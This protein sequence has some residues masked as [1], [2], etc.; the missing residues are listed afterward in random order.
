MKLVYCIGCGDLLQLDVTETKYCTC[1]NAGGKYHEGGLHAEYWGEWAV[2]V[3]IDSRD[4]HLAIDNQPEKG[5]G[6][7]FIAFVIPKECPTF[8]KVEDKELNDV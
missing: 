1:G 7:E 2:P 6:K 5:K 8:K 3:G 4:F